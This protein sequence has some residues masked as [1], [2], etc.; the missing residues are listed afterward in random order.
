MEM[1]LT[2]EA[3]SM[4]DGEQKR[5]LDQPFFPDAQMES[6]LGPYFYKLPAELRFLIFG[7][8]VASGHLQFMRASQALH[9][10]GQALIFEK[11]VF[12]TPFGA[13]KDLLNYNEYLSPRISKMI[14]NVDI[15][16]HL[17]RYDTLWHPLLYWT[18]RAP[19]L[20]S[21]QYCEVTLKFPCIQRFIFHGAPIK[22][23]THFSE[24]KKLVERVEVDKELRSSWKNKDCICTRHYAPSLEYCAVRCVQI[25]ESLQNEL[26]EGYLVTM[27]GLDLTFRRK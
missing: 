26:G 7:D 3:D 8:C 16:C 23:L 4:D 27:E 24:A 2:Q 20:P 5:S 17:E 19:W 11:G 6:G 15:T 18:R 9:N 14:R 10:D 21:L 1:S 25:Y 22:L 12:R 13:E